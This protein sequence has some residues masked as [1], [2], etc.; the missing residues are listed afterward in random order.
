MNYSKNPLMPGLP[1]HPQWLPFFASS[2]SLTQGN[3][4]GQESEDPALAPC[5]CSLVSGPGPSRPVLTVILKQIIKVGLPTGCHPVLP[6]APALGEGAGE[7]TGHVGEQVTLEEVGVGKG[8]WLLDKVHTVQ[9][10][11]DPARE[12]P[13][14]ASK[15]VL[16][17][18]TSLPVH[19]GPGSASMGCGAARVRGAAA[20]AVAAEGGGEAR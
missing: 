4:A 7:N 6:A 9:G 2:C 1:R 20:G 14:E 16:C 17:E 3:S 8:V 11:A 18:H 10:W 5:S 15:V 13:P 12:T 19:P